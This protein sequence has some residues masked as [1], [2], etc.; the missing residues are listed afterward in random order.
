MIHSTWSLPVACRRI[1]LSLSLAGRASLAR[2]APSQI[3]S[4]CS[5]ACDYNSNDRAVSVDTLRHARLL[6]ATCYGALA[7]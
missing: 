4:I 1:S 2:R 5:D 7:P 6:I 3:L